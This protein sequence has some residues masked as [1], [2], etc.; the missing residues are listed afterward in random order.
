[1]PARSCSWTAPG[2]ACRT[3]IGIPANF[4]PPPS[5]LACWERRTTPTQRPRGSQEL[6]EWIG[7]H[8]RCYEFHSG[9]SDIVVPDN[10]KTGVTLTHCDRQ[11]NRTYRELSR[12]DSVAVIPSLVPRPSDKTTAEAAYSWHSDE[13]S[14]TC[15][16][17]SSSHSRSC[18]LNS[19][20]ASS[21]SCSAAST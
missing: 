11:L 2:R 14:R 20:P 1:M 8:V 5:S 10:P 3:R 9:V 7:S 16:T 19:T 4:D 6:P 21:R 13:F 12:H 17:A 15:T 18:S